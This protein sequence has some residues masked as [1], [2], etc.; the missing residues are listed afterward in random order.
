MQPLQKKLKEQIEILSQLDTEDE[1]FNKYQIEL[2]NVFQELVVIMVSF[3]RNLKSYI[4]E[5]DT[6]MISQ[7]NTELSQL[8]EKYESLGNAIK[9]L[10]F[11]NLIP[12]IFMVL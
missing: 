10:L 5:G 12:V 2:K 8:S 4:I 3:L 6:N 7:I 9:I 1:D 11:E